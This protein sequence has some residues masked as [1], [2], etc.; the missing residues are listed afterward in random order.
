M[1]HEE[2]PRFL[3][4]LFR[5]WLL[6]QRL[7]IQHR[8]QRRRRLFKF[9]PLELHLHQLQ[10]STLLVPLMVLRLNP[11]SLHLWLVRLPVV[12]RW[13]VLRMRLPE[14]AVELEGLE[15]GVAQVGELVK[16]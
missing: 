7:L 15:M 2:E 11:Q 10:R 6:L 9:L 12:L 1:H 5:T 8:N 4:M 3:M 16:A 14:P 13:E